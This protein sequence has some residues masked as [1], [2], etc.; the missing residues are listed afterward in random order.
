MPN[1]FVSWSSPDRTRVRTILTALRLRGI[2]FWEY[3]DG[4]P[5]GGNIIGEVAAAIENASCAVF[6]FSDATANR[7]WVEREMTLARGRYEQQKI[8]IIPIWVGAHPNDLRPHDLPSNIN[9]RDL[10]GAGPAGIERLAREL[11]SY[12]DGAAITIPAAVFAMTKEQATTLFK[13][14]TASFNDCRRWR[15]EVHRL[16]QTL[17]MSDPPHLF[18]FLA[19]RYRDRPEDFTPFRDGQTISGIL[20]DAL[21]RLNAARER[22][23]PPLAI[24]WVQHD[25]ED[26]TVRGNWKSRPSLLIADSIS[27]Y[28]PEIKQR[29]LQ[30]PEIT[31]SAILWVPPYTQRTGR[32]QRYV[33]DAIRQIQR[34]EDEFK[35]SREWP[36]AFDATTAQVVDRWFEQ[37][38]RQIRDS[39]PAPQP[40]NVTAMR[41]RRKHQSEM[42]PSKFYKTR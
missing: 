9:V 35:Q 30:L 14:W 24:T 21:T 40:G 8:D 42:E 13:G 36:A 18:Q 38:L 1:F 22:K 15:H 6:L 10:L 33:G 16:C 37:T 27:M 5:A 23:Q 31:K 19:R 2:N 7:E 32:L 26:Q 25:F 12:D 4:M 17:G 28:H 20:L 11:A 29:V 34:F 39:A 41:N 3:M